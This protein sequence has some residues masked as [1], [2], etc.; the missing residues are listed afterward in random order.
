MRELQ[1]HV[2]PPHMP[3][4]IDE[5]WDWRVKQG[6]EGKQDHRQNEPASLPPVARLD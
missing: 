5:R 2:K 4:Q 3:G 1:L 6:D